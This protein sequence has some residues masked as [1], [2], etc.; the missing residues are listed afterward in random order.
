M[1]DVIMNVGREMYG[2]LKYRYYIRLNETTTYYYSKS[3]FV[4]K[5]FE[6]VESGS[7]EELKLENALDRLL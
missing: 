5:A 7:F 2:F 6:Y 3:Q 1:N 4:R